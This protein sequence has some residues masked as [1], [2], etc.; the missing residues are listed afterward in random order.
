LKYKLALIF[1]LF[2]GIVLMISYFISQDRGSGVR[3]AALAAFC[4][5]L[6]AWGIFSGRKLLA[7]LGGI[8]IVILFLVVGLFVLFGGWIWIPAGPG[9]MYLFVALFLTV[10]VLEFLA[11]LTV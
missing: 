1:N 5:F 6:T 10:A 4:F 2:G 3:M 11:L 8:P 7:C 9:M